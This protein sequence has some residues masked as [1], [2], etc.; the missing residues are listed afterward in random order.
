MG[1]PSVL[2]AL[3]TSTGGIGTHVRSLTRELVAAGVRVRVAGSAATDELFGFSQLGAA[4]TPVE[5]ST[6]PRPVTDAR[7]VRGLRR[8]LQDV[9]VVH[10]H[11]LRAGFVAAAAV[12]TS[13]PRRPLVVTWHN[14]M[15]GGGVKR[16]LL[17]GLERAVARAAD[18]TLGA[19][20]DLVS[21]ARELGA[22]DARLGPVAAPPLRSPGRSREQVRAEL[23][24]GARPVLLAVGRLAPQK[25]YP[26]LLDAAARWAGRTPPPLV[27]VAGDGPLRSEMQ[28]RID[29]E[30]LPVRLLGHRPDVPD[31]LAAA[32]AVVLPSAWEARAL[33]A[34]EALAAGIPLVATA[35][36][37]VPDMVGDAAVLV[38]YGD[39]R[40]LAAA[41]AHVLDD[42][43]VADRLASAGPRQAAGWP[44]EAAAAAQVLDVYRAL[45]IRR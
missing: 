1:E 30:Q 7:A 25:G 27:V 18:V 29:A 23:G 39:P 2:L 45:S 32:D 10:A 43:G 12:R 22:R 44:D 34:Q 41:V 8:L 4:F 31:L 15:L 36:G 33:V 40:A 13:R 19:S 24:A 6:L 35:V 42:P 3:A 14:A 20:S 37:G 16:H 17:A 26:L 21:R 9:D 5:V 38:P 28:Q 11:G